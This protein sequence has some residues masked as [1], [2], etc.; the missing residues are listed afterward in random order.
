M[1]KLKYTKTATFLFPLLDI[2]KS[3]FTCHVKNSFGK[4][5]LNNRFVNAYTSDC[6]ISEYQEGFVFVLV[7]Y[8]QDIDFQC[9]YDTV[10]A[11]DNYVDDYDRED[12]LVIVYSIPDKFKA[13]YLL[14][15]NGE[16]SK[17]SPDGKKAILQNNFFHPNNGQASTIPLILSKSQ[18]LKESW[19][20]R[21]DADLLD[22][23]VWSILEPK[24]EELCLEIFKQLRKK[25]K[26][27]PLEEEQL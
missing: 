22:Q 24:K 23:E 27:E 16:Y 18:A 11:F 14:V 5:V 3:I 8:Y 26:I 13:D 25:P 6:T 10:T 7:D 2:P 20:S 4:T 17:I 15:M 12:S 21:L 1:G 19:E 9:F